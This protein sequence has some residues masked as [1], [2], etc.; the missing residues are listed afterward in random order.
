[1]PYLHLERLKLN[2]V[3]LSSWGRHTT[4]LATTLLPH[5][6]WAQFSAFPKKLLE[7][8]S[9]ALGVWKLE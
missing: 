7:I 4:E 2:Q 5:Q 3:L 9:T 8:K 6:P 1:M